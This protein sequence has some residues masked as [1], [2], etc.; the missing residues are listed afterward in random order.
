MFTAR[1]ALLAATILV[2]LA[3]TSCGKKGNKGDTQP[4]ITAAPA[5][6]PDTPPVVAQE[7]KA[8]LERLKITGSVEGLADVFATVKK[9]GDSW[10]PDMGADPQA[11]IQAGLLGMGFGPGFW[12]NL[13]LDGLHAFSFAAPLQGGGPD[14]NSLSASVAVLDARKLIENMPQSQ[15]PSPLGEGMWQLAIETTQLL[16]REQ[17]KELLLG[18]STADV[19]TASKMRGLASPGRRFRLRATNLPTDDI[20]PAAVLEELPADSKLVQDLSKV[21]REL[22]AVTFE[23][24]VG[25]TRDLQLQLGATAPFHQLGLDPI[26]APR[27]S[28]TALESRLPGDPMF[29]TTMSWG[30]PALLHK[31]VDSLP[32]SELPEPINGMVQRAIVSTHALLDQVASDVAIALYIDKKGRATLVVAADVKD[33]AKT[34]AGLQGIHQVMLEGAQAQ[35]TMAGKNKDAALSAK[36]EL[37][38]LKVPGG[39]ADRLTVKFPKNLLPEV[40][41][42]G[43]FLS[44]KNSLDAI[45][46]VDEGTA[47]LAIGAGARSLVTDVAKSMGKVRKNSLAQHSGL[48]A[49]R[50]S[51]GG[52][53]ICVAG[54]PLDYLRFRLMLVR[55]DA[56]D[57]AIVK[58][59]GEKMYGLSKVRSIGEV[60]MGLKVQAE[61][62]SL[63]MLVPQGTLFAPRASVETLVEINEFV[64]SPNSGSAETR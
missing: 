48:E 33:E 63:G 26:G 15:R 10:M 13:D 21:L 3:A 9:I 29:V 37:D 8:P 25:T 44:K 24:D 18:F 7:P 42:A 54:D 16:M 17:G 46:H 40:R 27:A 39:K 50:K 14:D 5:V 12:G 61:D 60:A 55:D 58:K 36:L 19:D 4:P 47:I 31:L 59:A 62:A 1:R 11:D 43:M 23:T 56:Q 57:K 41:K 49:L 22:D 32:V 6:N 28:A 45:S 34:K 64:D 30:D 51:M 52:C 35:A 20:D 53:Q 2:P 38:G